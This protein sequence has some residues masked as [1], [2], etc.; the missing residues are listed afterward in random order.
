MA[1][2]TNEII[3]REVVGV[4]EAINKLG[5]LVNLRLEEIEGRLDNIEGRLDGVEAGVAAIKRHL[6]IDEE[7]E[8]I[9]TAQRGATGLPLAAKSEP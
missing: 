9:Q 1:S 2:V 3:L 4:G 6:R 5:R 8:N 7:L